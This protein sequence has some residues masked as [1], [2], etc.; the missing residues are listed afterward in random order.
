MSEPMLLDRLHLA[1]AFSDVETIRQR[2][3]QTVLTEVVQEVVKRVA[4]NLLVDLPAEFL[5]T[6]TQIDA[7]CSALISQDSSAAIVLIEQAQRVGASYDALCQLY[8][9]AA[10]RRL[11][12]WWNDDRLSFYKVTIGAG[13]IYAILRT[14]RMQQHPALPDGRR[15]AVFVSVPSD[16]HTLGIT[17]AADLARNRGWDVELFTGMS[18]DDVVQEL[19]R[20][21]TPLIGVSVSGKRML[22]ALIKL[23]VALRLSNPRSRI[24]VCGQVADLNMGLTG[25]A[26]ADAL[27][28]DFEQA[29]AYME[30]VVRG[31][32]DLSPA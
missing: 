17:V 22:P 23:I 4:N 1:Q 11:G 30:D 12:E 15:V 14:L 2:L 13:R 8:L 20:R 16:T 29:F 9:A 28:G 26:G 10:A 3:P 24:L 25:V 7:L 32:N 21:E 18:H 19:Q 5:P 6:P 31:R 27:A